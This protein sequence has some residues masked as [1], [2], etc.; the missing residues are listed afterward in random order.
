[1]PDPPEFAA[2]LESVERAMGDAI[3]E[4][5]RPVVV[6]YARALALAERCWRAVPA[7]SIM[8]R[9]DRGGT[10]VHPAIDAALRAERAAADFGQA[11]GLEPSGK[12]AP[13]RPPGA[14]SSPDRVSKP[15]LR[16][17]E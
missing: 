6:R 10:K 9:T 4:A 3:T 16:V 1:M 11:L 2:I 15:K 7:K 17:A 14:A 8:G 5:N 12:R 13:G